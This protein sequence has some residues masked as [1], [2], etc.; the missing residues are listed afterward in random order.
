M[1]RVVLCRSGLPVVLAVEHHEVSPPLF[2]MA[3][4]QVQ[5]LGVFFPFVRRWI[6]RQRFDQLDLPLAQFG[7]GFFHALD[8]FVPG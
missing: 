5:T 7:Q 8:L 2:K 4:N 3:S 1:N 6:V